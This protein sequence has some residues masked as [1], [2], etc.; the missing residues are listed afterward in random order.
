MHVVVA[1]CSVRQKEK[2]VF[3]SKRWDICSVT[4]S[5]DIFFHVLC[6]EPSL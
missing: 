4:L 2:I 6:F 5:D 3:P 1:D